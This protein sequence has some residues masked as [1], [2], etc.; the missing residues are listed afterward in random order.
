LS[1]G[2]RLHRI[3]TDNAPGTNVYDEIGTAPLGYSFVASV[4]DR[5]I[6]A[7]GV[8]LP[9]LVQFEWSDPG[10]STVWPGAANR[11]QV[12]GAGE[13]IRWLSIIGTDI[14]FF[15]DASVE[16]WGHI[17]GREVFG[18]KLII[19]LVDKWNRRRRLMGESVV[20]AGDPPRP[21]FYCDND[22]WVLDGAKPQ[23]ISGAYRARIQ[24][25]LQSLVTGFVGNIVTGYDYAKEHVIRWKIRGIGTLV[26]DYVHDVW[27]EDAA[28]SSV[29]DAVTATAPLHGTSYMEF[30]NEAYIGIGD[31]ISTNGGATDKVYRW[32]PQLHQDDGAPLS[33]VRRLRFNLDPQ[34]T[35]RCRWN[36]LL[37]RGKRSAAFDLLNPQVTLRWWFDQ[38]VD[39]YDLATEPRGKAVLPISSTTT[40]ELYF[41]PITN[42]GVG[43]DV[44]VELEHAANVPCIFTHLTV[45]AK[46]LGR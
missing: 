22:F 18:R 46:A 5:V 45:G 44:T 3:R 19:P 30:G 11:S 35:H 9:E 1:T 14:Y 2:A 34:R 42:L 29:N 4:A 24:Q 43:R 23:R 21:F 8:A 41:E 32:S 31:P 15:K 33:V 20:L 10:S 27:T 12:T 36:R 40:G 39:R 7:G 17:G 26:Y 13:S 6:M 16:I 25:L 28:I 38:D 37:V